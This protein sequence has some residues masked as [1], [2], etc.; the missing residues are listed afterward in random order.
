MRAKLPS[1]FCSMLMYDKNAIYLFIFFPHSAKCQKNEKKIKL[2]KNISSANR[3]F[4]QTSANY[5]FLKILSSVNI[6]IYRRLPECLLVIL[7]SLSHFLYGVSSPNR[8]G[9]LKI[10]FNGFNFFHF[11]KCFSFSRAHNIEK[12]LFWC[13]LKRFL[14]NNECCR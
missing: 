5:D 9:K 14:L 4:I 10:N 12:N 8:G 2:K 3:L 7:H 6:K 1:R 11:L 13:G